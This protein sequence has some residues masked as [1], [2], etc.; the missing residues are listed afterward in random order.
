MLTS[1][2]LFSEEVAAAVQIERELETE[3][4]VLLSQLRRALRPSGAPSIP[5]VA[6]PSLYKPG[7]TIAAGR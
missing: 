2:G 3:D 5:Y 4:L 6:K 7:A 1:S